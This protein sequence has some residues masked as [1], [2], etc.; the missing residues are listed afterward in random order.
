MARSPEQ[1]RA[2]RIRV[3]RRRADHLERR[4]E[5]NPERPA[6]HDR[7]EASALRWAIGELESKKE[8]T[9]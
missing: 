8:S 3:L 7:T 5:E 2:R 4:I 6:D 9:E 1:I